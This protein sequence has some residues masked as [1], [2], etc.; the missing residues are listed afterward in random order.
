[1][2]DIPPVVKPPCGAT[3]TP[4]GRFVLVHAHPTP[5]A[6]VWHAYAPVRGPRAASGT[7][8]PPRRSGGAAAATSPGGTPHRRPR[9]HGAGRAGTRRRPRSAASEVVRRASERREERDGAGEV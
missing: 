2:G 5:P 1:M 6:H 9:R 3:N 4:P 7:D 8:R